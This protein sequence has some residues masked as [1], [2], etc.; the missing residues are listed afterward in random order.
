MDILLVA[1]FMATAVPLLVNW[2]L[3]GR[4]IEERIRP[5][6]RRDAEPPHPLD[7]LGDRVVAA[8]RVRV[9]HLAVRDGDGRRPPER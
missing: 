9:V 8:P 3:A 6:A 4:E 1:T 2:W 7:A 5:H